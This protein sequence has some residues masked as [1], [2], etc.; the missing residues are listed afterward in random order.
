MGGMI[1]Q[2]LA[3]RHPHRVGALALVATY[4]RRGREV[5]DTAERGSSV[6]GLP[7]LTMLGSGGF[8][9]TKVDPQQ[10][11][12]FL[13]P[14]VFSERFLR[15][16][17]KWLKELWLRAL[18]NGFSIDGFLAQL[19]AVMSHDTVAR[20]PSLRMPTLVVTGTADALV[21]PHHSD[22]LARL[23]PGA[24]L[25]RIDGATHGLNLEIPDAFN[26]LL[27]DF[28]AAHPVDPPPSV[29]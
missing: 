18:A 24:R 22:E 28:L 21:P 27:L 9:L 25:T 7:S 5:G 20:L 26:A 23:I 19:G 4:A 14:L 29:P 16:E 17:R 6:V 15:E 8:D 12:G 3:L 1:A 2:E 11:V 10:L 13:M